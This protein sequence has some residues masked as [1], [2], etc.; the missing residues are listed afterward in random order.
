M[1]ERPI[2]TAL[3]DPETVAALALDAALE[4]TARA[5]A[6][7]QGSDDELLTLACAL[8]ALPSAPTASRERPPPERRAPGR[9]HRR[10]A[11]V[12]AAAVAVAA[13]GAAALAWPFG[14]PAPEPA[15]PATALRLGT[16]GGR[17]RLLD[18][19]SPGTSGSGGPLTGIA[20]TG[21]S[22]CLAVGTDGPRALLARTGDGGSRWQ[23]VAIP[24]SVTALSGLACASSSDCLAV[25]TTGRHGVVLASADGGGAWTSRTVPS[26]VTSLSS[27]SC[28]AVAT[29]WAVGDSGAGAVVVSTTDG[30]A[31]WSVQRLPTGMVSL[32]AVSC[33]TVTVCAA[34]GTTATSAAIVVTS[35]AGRNWKRSPIPRPTTGA[36]LTDA[37]A[38]ACATATRC[39][40]GATTAAAG[41]LT[42]LTSSPASGGDSPWVASAG[43]AVP[44]GGTVIPRD[45][46][47]G[48]DCPTVGGDRVLAVIGDGNGSSP[49]SASVPVVRLSGISCPAALE[50]W[51]VQRSGRGFSSSALA[52]A[53]AP[54]GS[55]TGAA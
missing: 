8:R 4:L 52:L 53:A 9:R 55:T 25:G 42:V 11:L 33:P 5:D 31:H 23:R 39:W 37:A 46:T 30:G 40:A 54:S 7:P 6:G 17:V 45:A 14:A 2:L 50:C 1:A 26:A 16:N 21:P 22:Q 36:P 15:V 29:C 41:G 10:E 24:P 28:P 35:D 49:S 18:A 48:P 27:V 20:C 34:G 47:C 51:V 12:A 19:S 38:L 32:S 43:G 13:A 3:P 44:A